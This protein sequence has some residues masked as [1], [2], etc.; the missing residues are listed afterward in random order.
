MN[1]RILLRKEAK[2]LYKEQTKSIPKKQRLAFSEFYKRYKKMKNTD[3]E[4]EQVEKQIDEDF[5]FENFINVNEIND[6]DIEMF[7]EQGEE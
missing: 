2:R 6:D 4:P 3:V 7:D 1:S 5:N